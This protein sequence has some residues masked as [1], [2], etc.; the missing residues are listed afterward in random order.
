MFSS[1]AVLHFWMVVNHRSDKCP[2][3]LLG[4]ATIIVGSR[5]QMYMLH[6]LY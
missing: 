6:I 3:R 4:V 5:V 1:M 2:D